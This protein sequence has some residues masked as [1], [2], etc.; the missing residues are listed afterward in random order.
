MITAEEGII[1]LF[2]QPTQENNCAIHPVNQL[3]NQQ[4]MQINQETIFITLQPSKSRENNSPSLKGIYAIQRVH[5][6]DTDFRLNIII[7]PEFSR[8]QQGL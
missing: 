1:A 3:V 2:T 7:W 8:Q 6:L 5:C 4:S